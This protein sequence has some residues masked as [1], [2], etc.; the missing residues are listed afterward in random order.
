MIYGRIYD[1]LTDD[2][3]RAW[4]KGAPTR[5][6]K[7][8]LC[9]SAR[10]SEQQLS[11]YWNLTLKS[12][13][14]GSSR[15]ST[16]RT[17]R[18]F[19]ITHWKRRPLSACKTFIFESAVRRL[20]CRD[21]RSGGHSVPDILLSVLC[22]SHDWPST[23]G[24]IYLLKGVDRDCLTASD[25]K[26]GSAQQQFGASILTPVQRWWCGLVHRYQAFACIPAL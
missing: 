2:L 10:P 20:Q 23:C 25:K 13:H 21:Y 4:K 26:V 18:S 12:K 1:I 7:F 22:R 14:F 5:K 3:I 17:F 8:E 19:N 6:R 15:Q 16:A 9:N 11:S 24:L